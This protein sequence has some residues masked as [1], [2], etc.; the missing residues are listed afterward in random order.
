MGADANGNDDD[1]KCKVGIELMAGSPKKRLKRLW[2]SGDTDKFEIVAEKLIKDKEI[3]PDEIPEIKAKAEVMMNPKL[4]STNNAPPVKKKTVKG[5]SVEIENRVLDESVEISTDDQ[6]IL[7]KIK[8]G[9][10]S[11]KA[12]A[13]ATKSKEELKKLYMVLERLDKEDRRLLYKYDFL[14]FDDEC[15]QDL[16]DRVDTPPFHFEIFKTMEHSR[17]SCLVCPRG[18]AK[19]TNARKYI[20]HQIVNQNVKFVLILGSSED[21]A[22]QNL[23]W[24]RDSLVENSHIMSTYGHLKNKDKWSETEFETST[25]IKVVAKGAGQKVR[26]ANEKGR[27]DLIYIDDIEDDEGV[28]SFDRRL[29]LTDWL[30]SAVLPALSKNGR[31]IMTGTI[32]HLDSLLR[33]VAQNKVRDHIPWDVLWYTAINKDSKG[34]EHALWPE[35]WSIEILKAK[36]EAEPLVFAKE[37]QNDPRSGKMAVFDRAEY[38]YIKEEDV[39]RDPK[40]K[41]VGVSQKIVHCMLTTDYAASEK[42]GTDYTVLMMTGMDAAENL[43]VLEYERFRTAD[44]FDI[45]EMIFEIAQGYWCTF[46]TSEKVAFQNMMK[47]FIET[48]MDKRKYPLHV[49]ELVR[50]GTRKLY[51]IKA[52]KAPIKAG[53]IFWMEHHTELEEELDHVTEGGLGRHD[54]VIDCLADAYSCQM[55]ERDHNEANSKHEINSWE[56]CLEQGWFPTV[57]EEEDEALYG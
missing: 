21:M 12:Q 10:L 26:G 41:V 11:I 32:L 42:K 13:K 27:P 35:M 31:V 22:G 49:E 37:Y 17:R 50:S 5:L 33:N 39:V 4:R 45:V 34:N 38:R 18:H 56:W 48:E 40:R 43:Y 6:Q 46:M 47:R 1:Y 24:V 23:R 51:R 14:K 29:K 20:L 36:R 44:L 15:F 2:M 7:K 55:A 53:K 19:S 30:L 25:G 8:E 16:Q 54:D 52:L 3:S 28:D 9:K 57:Q